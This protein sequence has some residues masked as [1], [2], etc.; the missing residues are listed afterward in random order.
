MEW[1][2]VEDGLEIEASLLNL[3]VSIE[4]FLA[5]TVIFIVIVTF[6]NI[7]LQNF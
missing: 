3:S 5:M 2:R 6:S 1:G 7:V 4:R